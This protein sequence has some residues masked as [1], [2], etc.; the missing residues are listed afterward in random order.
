MNIFKGG[1][2]ARVSAVI[3]HQGVLSNIPPHTLLKIDRL[4]SVY[5]QYS[6]I[7]HGSV[8]FFLFFTLLKTGKF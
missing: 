8:Q 5:A 4:F 1:E 2:E 3:N 7:A 6:E